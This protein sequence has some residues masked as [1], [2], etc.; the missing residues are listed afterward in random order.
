MLSDLLSDSEDDNDNNSSDE[1][2]PAIENVES[3]VKG[4]FQ[5]YMEDD[6]NMLPK[7]HMTFI[8]MAAQVNIQG[9]DVKKIPP[10]STVLNTKGSGYARKLT[11]T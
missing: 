6:M 10:F 7:N 3:D 1:E 4:P 5:L 2:S 8:L 9:F 11:F